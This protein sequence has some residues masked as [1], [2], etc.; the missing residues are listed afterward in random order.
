MGQHEGLCTEKEGRDRR[1]GWHGEERWEIGDALIGVP[2]EAGSE[3]RS[4][5]VWGTLGGRW[6]SETRK[7][8]Q[9]M[10]SKSSVPL[11][12]SAK[13]SPEGQG[14]WGT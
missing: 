14:N 11:G 9:L 12:S 8:R 6:G 10:G 3:T 7:R 4:R 5:V 2:P 1:R 13:Q